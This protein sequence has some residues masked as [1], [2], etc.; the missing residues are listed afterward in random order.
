M[1]SFSPTAWS[2]S[3]CGDC[4]HLFVYASMCSPAFHWFPGKMWTAV[5][6]SFV[7]GAK[8]FRRV[9]V[10]LAVEQHLPDIRCGETQ[11]HKFVHDYL[12]LHWWPGFPSGW[13]LLSLC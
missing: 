10:P 1:C 3:D 2:A 12:Y 8:M 4:F 7:R 11:A 13:R 9:H 5:L 6:S